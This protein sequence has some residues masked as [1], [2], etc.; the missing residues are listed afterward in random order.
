MNKI[1]RVL[2]FLVIFTS[3]SYSV[4]G[5]E[6]SS[7]TAS[8]MELQKQALMKLYNAYEPSPEIQGLVQEAIQDLG[9]TEEILVLESDT[10]TSQA[11][12][13]RALYP[14]LLVKSFKDVEEHDKGAVTKEKIFALY[15]VLADVYY[16][17]GRFNQVIILIPPVALS[18]INYA[19][20]KK[21][22]TYGK[23]FAV[24]CNVGVFSALILSIFT[25]I[26]DCV[27][28]NQESILLACNQ[29]IKQKRADIIEQEL[30][31]KRPAGKFESSTE[32]RRKILV[33]CLYDNNKTSSLKNVLTEA[34]RVYDVELVSIIKRMGLA[35]RSRKSPMPVKGRSPTP[36]AP[37]KFKIS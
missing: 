28:S 4:A 32:T 33:E 18:I 35:S 3:Y 24:S 15:R 34:K 26:G 5:E 17:H 7:V 2:A 19:L 20:G 10:L 13:L 12:A 27:E 29:L 8:F 16:D 25:V 1:Y 22:D 21:I 9:I 36:S 31:T 30:L 11:R 23:E 37:L 14:F 6:V